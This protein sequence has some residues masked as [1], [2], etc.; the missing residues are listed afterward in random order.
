MKKTKK[1]IHNN[2]NYQYLLFDL[3]GLCEWLI[4]Y[5]NYETSLISIMSEHREHT[6]NPLSFVRENLRSKEDHYYCFI[7]NDKEIITI[8]RAHIIKDI[9]GISAVHT[10]TKYRG[11]GFCQKNLDLFKKMIKKEFHNVKIF[12]LWVKKDNY[13]AIKCYEN[14]GFKII[15][16]HKK[17][18]SEYIEME[19]Y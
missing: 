4:N 3:E 19:C 14:T 8:I 2:K 16:Y 17:W 18:S 1:F 15:K 5:K 10:S 6:F 12:N 9:C 11:N 13:P 7:V